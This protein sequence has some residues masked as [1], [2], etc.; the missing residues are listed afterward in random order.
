[1]P[2]VSMKPD[3]LNVENR[4]FEQT[5]LRQPLFINSVP[6]SGT[7]LLRNIVRM[8]VPV[9]QQYHEQF[10]Q[11]PNLQQHLEAF[12]PEKN[13][14]SWGHLLFSDASAI[15][16]ANSRKVVLYRDPHTWVLA[17]A[18]FFLSDEF[19][20]NIDHVK[21]GRIRVEELLNL[22]ILG[23]YQKVPSMLDLYVHNAVAWLGAGN[24]IV[25]YED[26]VHAVKNIDSLESEVYFRKLL[27]DCGIDP[28]PEDWR[29]RV[30][31]G[32][33]RKQ[34]GTARENLSGLSVEI[35]N[36]LPEAQK[37]L[38]EFMAPGLRK[39]LGYE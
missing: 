38:I 33:D 2:R 6:K 20:G 29:E 13:Y 32:A 25:R 22:M 16:L 39:M 27:G 3:T 30:K 23:I 17:R 1:M 35:P 36:E 18:R 11:H 21:G 4:K 31:V 19:S 8:F 28:V 7:H 14:L 5:P 9:E 12:N 34:S 37:K 26:L 10:I 24:T 15:E